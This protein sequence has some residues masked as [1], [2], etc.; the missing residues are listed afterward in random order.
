M[1]QQRKTHS[2]DPKVRT[3]LEAIKGQRTINE[4]AGHYGIHP[5]QVMQV[6]S[7]LSPVVARDG[8]G[9]QT[10]GDAPQCLPGAYIPDDGEFVPPYCFSVPVETQIENCW[11]HTSLLQNSFGSRFV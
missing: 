2:A 3:A 7:A 4:I 11:Q 8:H 9:G 6:W 5:N 1:K 10:L